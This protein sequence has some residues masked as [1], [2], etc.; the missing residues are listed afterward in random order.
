MKKG[1]WLRLGLTAAIIVNLFA[2]AVPHA[3][4]DESKTTL[5]I[6]KGSITIGDGTVTGKTPSGATAAYNNNGYIITGASTSNVVTIKGGVEQHVTLE[7]ASI[8]KS[9]ASYSSIPTISIEGSGTKA[10]LTLSGTNTVSAYNGA[11]QKAA[12]SVPEGSELIIDSIDGT[13]SHSLTASGYSSAAVIGGNVNE[14]AG[15]ITINSGTITAGFRTTGNS[16]A[17]IGGGKGGAGGTIVINGGVIT[18]ESYNG[19]AAAIGGGDVSASYPGKATRVTI[20]GGTITAKVPSNAASYFYDAIG[21]GY[22]AT[23]NRA[24]NVQKT[25][26]LINGGN[27]FT[28]GIPLLYG[29]QAVNENGQTVYATAIKVDASAVPA[30]GTAVTVHY[31][32]Q[33]LNTSILSNGSVYLFLPAGTIPV[34]ITLNTTGKTYYGQAVTTTSTANY[35]NS[36]ATVSRELSTLPVIAVQAEAEGDSHFYYGT[37]V[38]LSVSNLASVVNKA[39]YPLVYGTDYTVEWF[40][41]A[42]ATPAA[43]AGNADNASKLT[44]TASSGDL[45]RA[46]FVAI[47]SGASKLEA[48][49]AGNLSASLTADW[50]KRTVSFTN[51]QEK[52][53]FGEQATI[54]AELSAGNDSVTFGS[55]DENVISIHPVTGALTAHK[56]GFATLTAAAAQNPTAK[57]SSAVVSRIVEVVPLHPLAPVHVSAVPGDK[58]AVVSFDTSS[59]PDGSLNTAYTVTAWSDGELI[60][61]VSGASSPISITGL[62]NGKAYTFTVVATNVT[63]DSPASEPSQEVTPIAAEVPAQVPDKPTN[64]I[65]E[66]GDGQVKIS[67]TEPASNGSSIIGYAVTAWTGGELV[68]TVNGTVSPINVTGLENGKAYTFTIVAT[69][70][71][72]DS[73][74]SE[75]SEEVTPAAAETPGTPEPGEETPADVP[76]KPTNVTVTGGNGEATVAFTA[77]SANGSE[78]TL[79]TVTAWTGGTAVKTATGTSSPITVTGL[80]NGTAY[81]FTVVASN[82]VGNSLPSDASSVFVPEGG[83]SESPSPSPSPTSS[84]FPTP[85]SSPTPSP[86]PTSS[87]EPSGPTVPT[88]PAA[89]PVSTEKVIPAKESGEVQLNDEVWVIIPSGTSDQPIRIKVE[90]LKDTANL[91]EQGQKLASPIYELLKDF[92]G[93]FTKS[94]TLRFA[95]DQKILQDKSLTAAVFYYDETAKHWVEI[96]GDVNNGVISVQVDHFTK[97]AVFAVSKPVQKPS[98][99]FTDIAGHWAELAIK[100]AVEQALISGYPDGVFK[101]NQSIT[102]AE[103]IVVLAKAL[104]WQNEGVPLSFGDKDAIGTWAEKA[105]A[106]AVELK[107]ISGYN[108]GSFHPNAKITRAEIAVII[109]RAFGFTQPEA[110][111]AGGFADADAI[112]VWS[113]EAVEAAREKGIITGRSGNR[114]APNDEATRAEAIVL[115]LKALN[116]K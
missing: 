113:R 55:S 89:T 63:G 108:D 82:G 96:G 106:Q 107:V 79:Y 57:Q 38:T 98:A 12:I 51:L 49:N 83:V 11:T 102:R 20:N 47:S 35:P 29:R 115:L 7:N 78:I 27:V 5:D 58:E 44:I 90:K 68:K 32:G 93:N 94:I 60:K 21:T 86:T 25:T 66:A 80:V 85:T 36:T 92:T 22:A 13:D 104:N 81:T 4:A 105:V 6:S 10:Y 54:A 101:P 100:Q 3:S 97:F 99:Q 59:N 30:I 62:E 9:T 76:G 43:I 42:G 28:N 91:V 69:N 41:G 53:S 95:F 56:L 31:R 34:D 109:S 24:D 33:T 26:V 45:Y 15:S 40:K 114:F 110:A 75:P 1:K 77:P 67:F 64:V 71:I 48:G 112:P 65:A 87:S 17:A 8:T 52:Y 70:S 46:K 88:T 37:P 103:F 72:G 50:L 61:T 74:A 19:T 116:S 84:P 2:A 23:P 16:A 73:P 18:A 111:G 39:G 14:T